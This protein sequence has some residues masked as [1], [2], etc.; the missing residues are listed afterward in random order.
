[1][2]AV[3]YFHTQANKSSCQ[4]FDHLSAYISLHFLPTFINWLQF[5]SIKMHL[6]YFQKIPSLSGKKHARCTGENLHCAAANAVYSEHIQSHSQNCKYVRWGGV[7]SKVGIRINLSRLSLRS[8][9]GQR[10]PREVAENNF[11]EWRTL[12]YIN[13]RIT[14]TQ[15]RPGNSV[16]AHPITFIALFLL[17][18]T[19]FPRRSRVVVSYFVGRSI[20]FR[21]PCQQS[22]NFARL[23][24]ARSLA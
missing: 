12:W 15:N 23:D 14:T 18:H 2:I 4:L 10:A 5:S 24:S 6:K 9:L 13:T 20:S 3:S 21:S 19:R 7:Y 1:M 17:V 11:G 22:N 16:S 8:H